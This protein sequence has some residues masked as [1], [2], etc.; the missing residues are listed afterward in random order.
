MW[1]AAPFLSD[2]AAA[3]NAAAA[4]DS[5]A[6]PDSAAASPDSAL[7]LNRSAAIR[8][9]AVAVEWLK[10]TDA[11]SVSIAVVERGALAYAKAYGLARLGPPAPAGPQ[12]RYAIDS[13]SK[14]F[15]AAAA[16]LLAQQGKLSLDDRLGRW[17]AD[18]G[19]A[20]EVTL[21]QALT[22]T[23]GIRDYLRSILPPSI[24]S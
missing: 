9:D 10:R 6:R 7:L 14:E 21:H 24:T 2:V 4:S 20:S 11:P 17:L 3:Q 12:I 16:L 22:H 19:P 15:T 8:I 13:V 5:A 23:S 1:A 18:L